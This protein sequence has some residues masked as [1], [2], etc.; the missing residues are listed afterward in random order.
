MTTI[1]D[2]CNLYCFSLLCCCAAGDIWPVLVRQE[3][4]DLRGGGH[5]RAANRHDPQGVP[6]AHG[7]EQRPEPRVQRGVLCLQEGG[8]WDLCQAHSLVCLCPWA[9]LPSWASPPWFSLT[10]HT[11]ECCSHGKGFIGPLFTAV[12][13]VKLRSAF[14]RLL[15]FA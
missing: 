12:N 6:H 4:W 9:A 14:K 11:D 2:I 10:A 3:D 1:P 7:D 8:M 13:D 5:V 15:G